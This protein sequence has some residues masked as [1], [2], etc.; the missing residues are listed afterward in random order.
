MFTVSLSFY[1]ERRDPQETRWLSRARASLKFPRPLMRRFLS[2]RIAQ[3]FAEILE[4]K[5]SK[6]PARHGIKECPTKLSHRKRSKEAIKAIREDFQSQHPHPS[7]KD[8]LTTC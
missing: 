1:F 8:S 7:D 5:A 4:D 2:W 3:V 6:P